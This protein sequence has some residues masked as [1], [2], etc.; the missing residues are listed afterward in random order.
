MPIL[1]NRGKHAPGTCLPSN[2]T[3]KPQHPARSKTFREHQLAA[4][5]ELGLENLDD[6]WNYACK[7][8]Q[9]SLEKAKQNSPVN[10]FES[11]EPSKRLRSLVNLLKLDAYTPLSL[12]SRNPT[13]VIG[14]FAAAQNYKTG[15]QGRSGIAQKERSFNNLK[16]KIH[17]IAQQ[18]IEPQNV[19]AFVT[20]GCLSKPRLNALNTLS[21]ID[22]LSTFAAPLKA[23]M[24]KRKTRVR[25]SHQRPNKVPKAPLKTRPVIISTSQPQGDEFSA[26]DVTE[27]LSLDEDMKNQSD[28]AH[29][30][31]DHQK[32]RNQTPHLLLNAPTNAAA[33]RSSVNQKGSVRHLCGRKNLDTRKPRH[34]PIKANISLWTGETVCHETLIEKPLSLIRNRSSSIQSFSKNV[35]LISVIPSED[36]LV[37]LRPTVLRLKSA[38]KEDDITTTE[39]PLEQCSLDVQHDLR[40]EDLIS[41]AFIMERSIVFPLCEVTSV[42]VDTAQAE[43]S[44]FNDRL[45][46]FREGLITRSL[47]QLASSS[48]VNE[49]NVLEEITTD[50]SE[51]STLHEPLRGRCLVGFSEM[52]TEMV[53]GR[54]DQRLLTPIEIPS[55]C[56]LGGLYVSRLVIH[57][58]N[59]ASP[60]QT[61]LIEPRPIPAKFSLVCSPLNEVRGSQEITNCPEQSVATNVSDHAAESHGQ[62]DSDLFSMESSVYSLIE[63]LLNPPPRSCTADST[64]PTNVMHRTCDSPVSTVEDMSMITERAHYYELADDS[65]EALTEIMNRDL[66]PLFPSIRST[67]RSYPSKSEIRQLGRNWVLGSCLLVTAVFGLKSYNSELVQGDWA[68]LIGIASALITIF[69]LLF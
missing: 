16:L 51:V 37:T 6:I 57:G 35:L 33:K 22:E 64:L 26:A 36:S 38:F 28:R 7:E 4:Q 52:V 63:N 23:P 58:V 15:I 44:F 54:C 30:L 49:D 20:K 48:K 31:G 46:F 17:R 14:N 41:H 25:K 5:Q 40:F 19:V 3:Q 24:K 10:I 43:A 62:L 29:A 18:A 50:I 1:L 42:T 45:H 65:R 8:I 60:L 2:Q 27:I 12:I 67:N 32:H 9:S 66:S 39:A 34:L 59:E 55:S 61:L 21:D 68:S 47:T 13:Q 69:F 11:P 53:G 56:V